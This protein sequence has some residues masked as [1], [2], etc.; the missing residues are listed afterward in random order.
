[1]GSLLKVSEYG[2][3]SH[4][5]TGPDSRFRGLVE[6]SAH[7]G[8]EGGLKASPSQAAVDQD[9]LQLLGAFK[10]AGRCTHFSGHLIEL[11][12]ANS[13]KI[14]TYLR[15]DNPAVKTNQPMFFLIRCIVSDQCR[16][17]FGFRD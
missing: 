13:D 2:P 14:Q 3:P 8:D 15:C 9:M 4:L 10:S 1:M 7:S 5:M 11:D 12:V 6:E 17:Q 16:F